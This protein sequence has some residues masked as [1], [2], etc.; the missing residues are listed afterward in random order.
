VAA[1]QPS[2]YAARVRE[3]DI[4][5]AALDAE[6]KRPE[7]QED[8]LNFGLNSKPHRTAFMRRWSEYLSLWR[9]LRKALLAAPP[10]DEA[11]AL[12]EK[13]G[14]MLLR[15]EALLQEIRG[16]MEMH[17]K[18]LPKRFKIQPRKRGPVQA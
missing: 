11:Q 18:V 15:F 10:E 12:L 8:I 3:L 16:A 9:E 6:I 7:V 1:K 2:P 5:I 14:T 13:A 17:R 4:A